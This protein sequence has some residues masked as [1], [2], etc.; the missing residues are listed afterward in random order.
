[1]PNADKLDTLYIDIAY[2]IAQMSHATRAKVGCII[3]KGDN[4]ISMGWNGMPKGDANCCEQLVDGGGA[5]VTRQ[6]VLHSE[7]NALMKLTRSGGGTSEGATLYTTMSPCLEC[8]KL[9]KQAGITRV[10]YAEL[11]RAGEGVDFLRNR[12]V[13]VHQIIET[14]AEVCDVCCEPVDEGCACSDQYRCEHDFYSE[15]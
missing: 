3:V 10:V 11:Y 1:M 15:R 8:A 2:R 4:I 12:N 14:E 6:E 5:L 13:R 7:S 9:I